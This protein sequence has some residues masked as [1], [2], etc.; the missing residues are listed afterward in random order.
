MSRL[1]LG[2]ALLAVL[3]LGGC[4]F[5]WNLGNRGT[6][7]RDVTEL[8]E[9]HGIALEKPVCHMIGTTRDAT[10]AF[11]LS[12]EQLAIAV[13]RLGLSEMS[14]GRP[15][16]VRQPSCELPPAVDSGRP[17]RAYESGR[18]PKGRA[19]SSGG[20]FS[21]LLLYHRADTREVCVQVSY[22]YG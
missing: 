14:E 11:Q 21:Y 16:G 8:F 7:T 15:R 19:L 13:Q 4:E 3:A 18:Q 10:C 2:A 17:I 12:G 6:L 20:A 1:R 22:A 5:L 9:A